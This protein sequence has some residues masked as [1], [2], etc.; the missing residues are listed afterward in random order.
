MT[1]NN[2]DKPEVIDPDDPRYKDDSYFNRSPEEQ[3]RSRF[4][5]DRKIKYYS[6]GCTPFGCG[7]LPAVAVIALIIT[8]LISLMS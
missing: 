6:F 2:D 4:E 8:W 3:Q 5:N 7:C 1:H